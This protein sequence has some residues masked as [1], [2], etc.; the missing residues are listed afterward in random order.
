MWKDSDADW[1]IVTD[2]DELLQIDK[3]EL[4]KEGDIIKFV[5]Y[6]MIRYNE[7]ESFVDLT[8]GHPDTQMNKTSMFRSTIDD[9]I[10]LQVVIM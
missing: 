2:I 9:I 1:I 6:Q 10:I 4:E 7:D 3:E 5:G 8:H